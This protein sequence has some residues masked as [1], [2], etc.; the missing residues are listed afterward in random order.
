MLFQSKTPPGTRRP[1]H[2]QRRP[3]PQPSHG[4]PAPTL[5]RRMECLISKFEIYLPHTRQTP[6]LYASRQISS[7]PH[8]PN[9]I[10]TKLPRRPNL[11]LQQGPIHTLP[12]VRRGRRNFRTRHPPLPCQREPKTDPLPRPVLYLSHK[13]PLEFI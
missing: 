6:H 1:K 9:A 13:P 2:R 3:H 11:L 10:R 5:Q 8:P 12:R 4:T 7:L